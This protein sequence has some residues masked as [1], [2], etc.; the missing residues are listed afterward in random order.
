MS[1]VPACHNLNFENRFNPYIPLAP[2]FPHNLLQRRNLPEIFRGIGAYFTQNARPPRITIRLPA[3]NRPI[4][5]PPEMWRNVGSFLEDGT[6]YD[7][8]RRVNRRTAAGL[9]NRGEANSYL[10][11]D[12][13][14]NRISNRRTLQLNRAIERT[15]SLLLHLVRHLGD[16]TVAR[17]PE[18]VMPEPGGNNAYL[19]T[20]TGYI[21]LITP[22][23]MLAPIVRG[24]DPA[25]RH[26][27]AF[28]YRREDD[29][30]NHRAVIV[31]HERTVQRVEEPVISL[32][33]RLFS[34]RV[35]QHPPR[36]YLRHG[37]LVQVP[38]HNGEILSQLRMIHQL[39]GTGVN[40]TPEQLVQNILR[41]NELNP[42]F[43]LC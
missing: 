26:F 8:L 18:L 35:T 33:Q 23:L 6:D 29:P 24:V 31:V 11:F 9:T 2:F 34:L 22:D 3:E 14:N 12:P 5:L 39:G 38:N 43:I 10:F 27:I 20:G 30:M 19:T 42:G 7:N 16:E 36:S 15:N 21:D 32:G 13:T 40:P 17:I 28:R 37:H 25:G 41:F 1:I 4:N